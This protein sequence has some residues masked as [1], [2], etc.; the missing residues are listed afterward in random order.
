MAHHIQEA[1]VWMVMLFF[2]LA[3]DPGMLDKRTAVPERTMEQAMPPRLDAWMRY[4]EDLD[5]YYVDAL[6]W[7]VGR[8]SGAICNY[9]GY[10]RSLKGFRTEVVYVTISG[11]A[12]NEFADRLQ[13]CIAHEVGHHID[14]S[15]GW[16][17]KTNRFERHVMASL[18]LLNELPMVG[19]HRW[20]WTGY[21]IAEFPGING[22]PLDGG[23]GGYVE[24]YASLHFT[25]YLIEIPPPLRQYFVAFVPWSEDQVQGP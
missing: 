1:V 13:G 6:S 4:A 25:D 21:R 16:L 22:N 12:S 18:R 7:L 14:H 11:L 19:E 10:P 5:Y 8:P 3:F 15:Q 9:K 24:L 20:R 23:W 17:S 2:I